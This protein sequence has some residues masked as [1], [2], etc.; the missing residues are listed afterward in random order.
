MNSYKYTAVSASGEQ[1]QGMIEAIDQL[2]ATAKIRQQYNVI[3]SID[4]IRG[5]GA[6]MPGFLN[7]DIGGK[8]L[9]PKAFTLM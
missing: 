4:E 8:R 7:I 1:I 2:E 6:A 9:D 5:K 3:L